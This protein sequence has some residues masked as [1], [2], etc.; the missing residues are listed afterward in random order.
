VAA[1]GSIARKVS[2]AAVLPL[3]FAQRRREGDVVI[4]LYHRVGMGSREIDLTSKAFERQIAHLAAREYTLT[5]D[6]A[7][8]GATAGGIV[9]TFDDGYRDFYDHVLPVLVRHGVPALLYLATGFVTGSGLVGP[10]D[11]IAWSQLQE[12]VG[13]G[14][15][16]VGSH[17]HSH[18]DLS[19]GSGNEANE[20]IR[21]SKGLIEER[22]QRPCDHFA[23][24]WGVAS[25]EAQR[26]ARRH[27]GTVALGAWRTNRRGQID[28]YRLGRTPV[29]RSDGWAF[30]RAK[31]AGMLDQEALLYRALGRGPWRPSGG[32]HRLVATP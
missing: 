20:E 19:R 4:L 16:T 18:V 27:F 13:T 5:L 11:G 32:D 6:R 2:K 14:L 22:L 25:L 31:V 12:A 23:F 24:P 30:F 1:W 15:V 8:D 17:T 29:L 9:L 7:V 10:E 26:E 21:R 3:G 28:P